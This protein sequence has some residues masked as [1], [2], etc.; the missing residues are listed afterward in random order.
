MTGVYIIGV[1]MIRF[2][3]YPDQSVRSMAEDATRLA[4]QDSGLTKEDLQAAF[5]SNSFG[6]IGEYRAGRINY[7]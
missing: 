6:D 2:G 7:Y 4:L 3:K 5:F 1:G